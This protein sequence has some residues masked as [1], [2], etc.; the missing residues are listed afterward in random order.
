KLNILLNRE[1]VA[2]FNDVKEQQDWMINSLY[3]RL[4]DSFKAKAEERRLMGLSQVKQAVEQTKQGEGEPK[5]E[6][7]RRV[8]VQADKNIDFLTIKKVMYTVKEAGAGE[9]NFAVLKTP[10]GTVPGGA[11][12]ATE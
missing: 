7:D 11:P 3:T 2:R 9:I 12:A 5:P 8:T 6:D 4:Q 1:V 10:A